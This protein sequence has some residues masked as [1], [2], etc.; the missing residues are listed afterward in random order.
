V[1]TLHKGR[2]QRR[3]DVLKHASDANHD[4]VCGVQ[5]STRTQDSDTDTGEGG[6][7][8]EVMHEHRACITLR[9]SVPFNRRK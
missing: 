1:T 9:V 5:R 7:D 6:S 8:E 3:S 4:A 2:T